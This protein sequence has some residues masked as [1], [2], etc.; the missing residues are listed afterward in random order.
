MAET[1]EPEVQE[2]SGRRLDPELRVLGQIL[3]LLEEVPETGRYRVMLY[4]MNRYQD[5]GK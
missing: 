2:T 1:D 5:S 3:R 4:L